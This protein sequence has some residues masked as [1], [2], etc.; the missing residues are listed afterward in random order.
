M[1]KIGR[2][3][4]ILHRKYWCLNRGSQEA[5]KKKLPWILPHPIFPN[6]YFTPPM[7]LPH[8]GLPHQWLYPTLNLPHPPK[9][10]ELIITGWWWSSLDDFLILDGDDLKFV[11]FM[12]FLIIWLFSFSNLFYSTNSPTKWNIKK[13]MRFLITHHFF[14]YINILWCILFPTQY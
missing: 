14:F 5:K 11:L 10:S 3:S 2:L 8:L 7:T 9:G 6:L 1:G 4:S 12:N 13:K